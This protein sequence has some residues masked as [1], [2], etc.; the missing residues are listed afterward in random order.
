MSSNIGSALAVKQCFSVE[1]Q[2]F[3]DGLQSIGVHKPLGV[4]LVGEG[5]P[6]VYTTVGEGSWSGLPLTRW[7]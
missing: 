5:E 6:M 2:K 3:L 4:K 7:L 1:P